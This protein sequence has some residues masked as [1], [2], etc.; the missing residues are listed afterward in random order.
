MDNEELELTPSEIKELQILDSKAADIEAR[1]LMKKE[2]VNKELEKV[3]ALLP[4]Y[5]DELEKF[6]SENQ[7]KMKDAY[8]KY[9]DVFRCL[10]Q[11]KIKAFRWIMG[12]SKKSSKD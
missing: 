8:E 6:I 5:F 7:D 2:K 11:D 3:N 1:I 12:N 4:A 9:K 10:L